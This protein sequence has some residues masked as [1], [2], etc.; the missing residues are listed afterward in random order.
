M[1]RTKNIVNIIYKHHFARYLIVGGSTFILDFSLLI[2]LHGYI[3]LGLALAT[4]L[5][6]W[7]SIIYNFCLN[8]WWSFSVAEK[9]SLHRHLIPYSILLGFNYLFTVIFIGLASHFIYYGLAKV[10]A[11]AIQM[12]WTYFIYKSVIFTKKTENS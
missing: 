7:V 3:R 10:F 12:S 1:D 4:T 6:Y 11:V 9:A 8:R 5:A 2:S